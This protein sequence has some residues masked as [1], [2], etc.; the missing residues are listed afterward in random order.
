MRVSG[1][2]G[3]GQADAVQR[4]LVDQVQGDGIYRSFNLAASMGYF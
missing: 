3:L 2:L 1:W 4:L